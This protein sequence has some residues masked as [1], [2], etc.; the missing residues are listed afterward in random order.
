M[1]IGIKP[2][3]MEQDRE[4]ILTRTKINMDNCGFQTI[5]Q[6]K[7]LGSGSI[8]LEITSDCESVQRLAENL[9]ELDLPQIMQTMRNSIVH[10]TAGAC[11]RHLA[12]LIP[13]AIIRTVE[14]EVGIALPGESS[15]SI[16]KL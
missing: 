8:R 16:E 10:Q 7:L 9:T 6:G 4:T 11:L 5:I 2:Y 15:I 3:A 14:V 12:C 13:A 1:K